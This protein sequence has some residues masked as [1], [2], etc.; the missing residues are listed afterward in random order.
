MGYE[1]WGESAA[2]QVHQGAW[3]VLSPSSYGVTGRDK[4][5]DGRVNIEAATSTASHGLSPINGS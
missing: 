3:R 5:V 2:T 4:V 1:I